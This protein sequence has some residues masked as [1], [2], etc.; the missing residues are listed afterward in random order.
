ME[1]SSSILSQSLES[2]PFIK[3]VAGPLDGDKWFD[4][5]KEE[6]TVLIQYIQQNKDNDQD[7]FYVES[8]EDG[9]K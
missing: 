9:T 5:L 4:R 2:L 7:W 3:T 1:S 6:Y 8:N